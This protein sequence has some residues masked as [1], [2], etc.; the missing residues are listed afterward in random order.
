[1]S[2]ELVAPSNSGWR[3]CYYFFKLIFSPFIFLG[4][5]RGEGREGESE[6]DICY[7]SFVQKE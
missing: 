2:Y 3:V 6:R 7:L 1:M 4:E 5:G